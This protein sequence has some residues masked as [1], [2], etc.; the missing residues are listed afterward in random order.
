METRKKIYDFIVAYI[1]EHCYSPTVRKIG[2]GVGLKS[3]NTAW[4]HLRKMFDS[5]MIETDAECA[6]R[7]IRVP[8]YEFVRKTE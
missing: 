6:P 7:A 3:T 1:Q 8:G 4:N 2:D 5:G